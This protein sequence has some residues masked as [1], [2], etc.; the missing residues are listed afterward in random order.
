[1]QPARMWRLTRWVTGTS[2]HQNPRLL[3]RGVVQLA[4]PALQQEHLAFPAPQP[5]HLEM[6]S[7]SCSASDLACSSSWLVDRSWS[8]SASMAASR[9]CS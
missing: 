2:A 4:S 8:Q 1:M 9:I 5:T 7:S 6:P 3:T